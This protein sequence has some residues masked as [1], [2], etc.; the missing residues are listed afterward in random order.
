MGGRFDIYRVRGLGGKSEVL[1]L[2]AV[3]F[4]FFDP[5]LAVGLLEDLLGPAVDVIFTFV[6]QVSR[7][8]LMMMALVGCNVGLKK[9]G[10]RKSII[11]DR[12]F[13]FAAGV[14]IF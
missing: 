2:V 5:F 14:G 9:V 10:T 4:V 8:G 3:A 6:F 7:V 11:A 12:K 1:L 13:G